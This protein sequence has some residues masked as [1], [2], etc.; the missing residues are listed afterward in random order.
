MKRKIN[1]KLAPKDAKT[2]NQICSL[3]RDT[4]DCGDFWTII[5]ETEITFAEQKLGEPSRQMLS[6]P[7]HIFLRF[8]NWYLT[9]KQNGKVSRRS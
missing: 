6:M 8:V 3:E 9:G 4:I 2:F 1:K 7:R 5:D